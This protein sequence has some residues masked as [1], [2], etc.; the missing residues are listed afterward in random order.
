MA[1][2]VPYLRLYDDGYYR[3]GGPTGRGQRHTDSGFGRAVWRCPLTFDLTFRNGAAPG[4]GSIRHAFP[5]ATARE[6]VRAATAPLFIAFPGNVCPKGNVVTVH[7]KGRLIPA[8]I[9]PANSLHRLFHPFLWTNWP[10]TAVVRPAP[11]RS[12]CVHRRPRLISASD[13]A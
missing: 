3:P 8:I 10:L 13:A 7:E 11:V 6:T 9:E 1:A 12:C 4:A 5:G 2:G